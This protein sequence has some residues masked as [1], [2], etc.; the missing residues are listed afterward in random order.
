LLEE[1]KSPWE[2][3]VHFFTYTLKYAIINPWMRSIKDFLG[4]SSKEEAK[5]KAWY[6]R[7]WPG[8]EEEKK[9]YQKFNFV[10]NT[11]DAVV[12]KFLMLFGGLFFIYF[13]AKAIPAS[14]RNK[15]VK[16]QELE[17]EAKK[18]EFEKL[19]LELE[20][21]KIEREMIMHQ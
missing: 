2:R 12:R 4:L 14:F 6:Q 5:G 13:L 16:A 3:V 11:K 7:I 20:K 9:W 21:M 19:K 10:K 8:P 17:L 1:N 15:K 18:V